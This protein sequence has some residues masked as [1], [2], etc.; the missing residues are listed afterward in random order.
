MI[1]Y[2]APALGYILLTD[3]SGSLLIMLALRIRTYQY[4]YMTLLVCYFSFKREQ[5]CFHIYLIL[6]FRF[7]RKVLF[8]SVGP[9]AVKYI[10]NHAAVQ[11]IFC[12]PHTLNSVSIRQLQLTLDTRYLFIMLHTL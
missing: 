3:L 4:H 6:S 2:R 9:D 8:F 12:V 1:L 10:V 5:F 11:V 7:N